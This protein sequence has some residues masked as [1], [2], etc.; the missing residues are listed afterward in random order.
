M[1]ASRWANAAAGAGSV[2]S[3]AGDVD[4][5]HRGDRAFAG[6]GDALLQLAHLGFQGGLVAD[7]RGH[8]PEQRRYLGARLGEAEDIVDEEKHVLLLDVAEVLGD[9]EG[10]EAD[11]EARTGG[12]VHL[13][14]DERGRIDDARLL[15]LEPEVV[16]LAGALAHAGEDRTAAVL[17]G[18]VVDQLHDDDGLADAG[19]AEEARLAALHV[20]REQVHDLDPGLED[21]G[22]GL[23]VLEA[24]REA[25]DRPPLD[26]LAVV[27]DDRAL[28]VHRFAQHVEDAAQ[29]GL[30]HRDGDRPPRV[31]HVHPALHA[32]GRAHRHGA[33][34]G[35]A[36]VLLHL[37][38]EV[39]LAARFRL[40][41]EPEC[42]VNLGQVAR[43]VL[44]VQHGS[45]DLDDSADVVLR[46]D[47]RV[48][49][50]LVRGGSLSS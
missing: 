5:L 17:H 6:R 47:S 21:L 25:V 24:R 45:D 32:V 9:R 11:P 12:L 42:A 34:L 38:D 22:L 28:L 3:S 2:R 35:A 10:G 30:P 8:A 44:H 16:A 19:A 37:G 23:E 13:A 15:H 39:D 1:V 40:G 27:A 31:H 50:P 46:H 26:R 20:R 4:G 29:R 14:V 48:L 36:D 43:V 18:D 41:G 7:R 33:H 49:Q